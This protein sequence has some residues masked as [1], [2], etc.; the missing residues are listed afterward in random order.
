[1]N[2]CIELYASIKDILIPDFSQQFVMAGDLLSKSL[3][4]HEITM[5][6]KSLGAS[7]MHE[8]SSSNLIDMLQFASPEVLIEALLSLLDQSL[9][10]SIKL[11]VVG[12]NSDDY[13]M[14]DSDSARIS[15]EQV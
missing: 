12:S 5:G 15:Q 3:S 1:M 13:G 7:L 14:S 2:S 4:H 11:L 6:Q 10:K 8:L 9:E